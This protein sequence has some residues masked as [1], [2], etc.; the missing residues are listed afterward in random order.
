M[1][2]VF[3]ASTLIR[4]PG[5]QGIIKKCGEVMFDFREQPNVSL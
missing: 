1:T 2:H 5:K 3:H 4:K